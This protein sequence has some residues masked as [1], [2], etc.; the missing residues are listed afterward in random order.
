MAHYIYFAKNSG[1]KSYK[2]SAEARDKKELCEKLKGMGFCA[3]SIKRQR[4]IFTFALKRVAPAEL[5]IFSRQFSTMIDA[6][7]PLITSLKALE[8]QTESMALKAVINDI[9]ITIEGGASLSESMQRHPLVFSEFFIAL[10]KAGEAGG[11]LNTLLE[12]LAGHLEKQDNLKRT[13]RNAFTYPVIVGILA[14]LVVSFLVIVIVPVFKSVY[15][16]MHLSLPFPTLILIEVSNFVRNFWWLMLLLTGGLFLS[17]RWINKSSAFRTHLDKFKINMPVFGRLI[18]KATVARFVRTFGDMFSSGVPILESLRVSDKVAANQVV[19]K[20]ARLMA[21]NVHRG[22]L[23]SESLEEQD[24][25]PAVVIQ[26]I[27]SGE[28]SGR[29]GFMLR[30]AA[31]GLDRDVD[32]TVKRLVVKI[33]PLMT[34]LMALLVGFIAVA[35][36]LPIF[37]VIKQMGV[38]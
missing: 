17:C 2:G 12:R 20:A 1:G 30:K 22:G 35:I 33:E 27:A 24:I 29:L 16:R 14:F 9:R 15:A 5:V 3:V 8:K 32:D 26:M 21:D 37:D 11:I 23:I 25:F 28:E 19:S 34:F 10:I 4:A 6:G 38:R 13:V 18:R 7:L 31:D 36:Y